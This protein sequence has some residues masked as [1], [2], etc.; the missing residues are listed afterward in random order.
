MPHPFL[1][2]PVHTASTVSPIAAASP[3]SHG[4]NVETIEATK[5][6]SKV[7]AMGALTNT[8]NAEQETRPIIHGDRST[9]GVQETDTRKGAGTSGMIS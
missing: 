4:G 8:A 7:I 3:S 2:Q 9:V 6:P 5:D 1:D